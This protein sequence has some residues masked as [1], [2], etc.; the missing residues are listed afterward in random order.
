MNTQKQEKYKII[1]DTNFIFYNQ[2]DNLK[3]VFRT[4][5]FD[6]EKFINGN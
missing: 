6:L 5:L 2:D 4:N 1:V 3:K